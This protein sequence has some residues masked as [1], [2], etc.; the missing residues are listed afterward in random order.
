M[1][2]LSPASLEEAAGIV[3]AAAAAK[4]PLE[5]LGAGTKRGFG[6]PVAADRQV[7]TAA[8]SGIL[9]YHPEE[10][11]LTARA[12]THMREIVVAL[13]ERGQHLAF[14]PPDFTALYSADAAG[15]PRGDTLGGVLATNLAGPRRFA[16]GAAR[17]HFLGFTGVNGRGEIFKAGGQVVKN[18]TGYDLPKL[19]AG[20]FGTLALMDQVTVKTLPRPDKTR[21]V[22][23]YGL[24]GP[25]ASAAMT[26][27]LGGAYD[28]T[29]AAYLPNLLAQR[30]KAEFVGGHGSVTALRVEG[31]GPSSAHHCAALRRDLGGENEE[32]HSANSAVLW[33][34]IRD[35]AGFFDGENILWRVSVPPSHGPGIAAGFAI[36]VQGSDFYLDWGGGLIWLSLPLEHGANAGKVR[37]ALARCGGHATLIRAPEEVRRKEPVFEVEGSPALMQRVKQ[38]FDPD[39]VLDPGRMVEGI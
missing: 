32:L 17:D 7:T 6:R 33:R 18:V 22:L 9:S 14:E 24:D 38:A 27:A 28:V 23:L 1:D 31:S 36:E 16:A 3:R 37:G 15:S 39:G 19:M 34:E 2:L 29:G 35:V 10:L 13:A 30:S 8:M 20:S 11:V 5:I 25:A 4:T 12:G 21:T 26:K